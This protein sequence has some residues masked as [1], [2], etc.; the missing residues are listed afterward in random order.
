[1]VRLEEGEREKGSADESRF[2]FLYK[3]YGTM[4]VLVN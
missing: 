3:I 4:Y 2:F 1:M